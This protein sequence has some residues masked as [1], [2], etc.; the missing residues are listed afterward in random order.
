MYLRKWKNKNYEFEEMV[1]DEE[2][3]E[4]AEEIKNVLTGYLSDSKRDINK[5]YKLSVELKCDKVLR[6]YMEVLL[7]GV[8]MLNQ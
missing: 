1:N 4:E 8:E 6:T 3:E 5:L 2:G 7:W